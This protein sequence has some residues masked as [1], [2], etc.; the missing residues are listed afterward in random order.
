MLKLLR[1]KIQSLSEAQQ[2]VLIGILVLIN[3]GIVIFWISFFVSL[4]KPVSPK[5]KE[6]PP[7]AEEIPEP[8]KPGE[9]GETEETLK[10]EKRVIIPSPPGTPEIVLPLVIFNSSGQIKEIKEDGLVVAGDGSTFADLKPRDLTLIYISTTQT[11][12]STDK[13]KI[14][15]GLEGLKYLKINRLIVFESPENIRGKI[16]FEV[17]YVKQL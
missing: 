4:P 17:S 14:G 2:N 11:S 8:Y 9:I 16:E 5:I 3:I 1:N 10:G 15:Q 12:S 6:K 7:L 13:T